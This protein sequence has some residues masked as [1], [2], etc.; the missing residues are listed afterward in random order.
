MTLPSSETHPQRASSPVPQCADGHTKATGGLGGRS[1]ILKIQ[2]NHLSCTPCHPL[3]APTPSAGPGT[4]RQECAPPH[5]DTHTCMRA[6][7]HAHTHRLTHT[8][9]PPLT[10]P[11]P[12]DCFSDRWPP[13]TCLQYLLSSPLC[14]DWGCSALPHLQPIP[15][16]PW[17]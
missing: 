14:S 3:G 8:P 11:P 2:S 7:T 17:K 1:Q 9:P 16:T 15:G 5:T 6:C 10:P 13:L 4:P 12:A